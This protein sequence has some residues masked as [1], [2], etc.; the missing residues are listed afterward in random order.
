MSKIPLH[1][2]IADE[3][4]NLLEQGTHRNTYQDR[5]DNGTIQQAESE[6]KSFVLPG[7][8]FIAS[9]DIY[10]GLSAAAIKLII[11]IQQELQMNNPLWHCPDHNSG[12]IRS[13]LAQ[14]KKKGILKLIEGTDIFIVNPAKIRKGR[15]LSV[16]GALYSYAKRMYLKDKKW[17]PTTD[18]IKKLMSPKELSVVELTFAS[19]DRDSQM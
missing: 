18:D 5:L 11:R 10:V 8:I 13:A 4:I 14:L 3:V 19:L 12:Q 7:E 16:Y 1:Y 6:L 2:L 9:S 15:P 17:K